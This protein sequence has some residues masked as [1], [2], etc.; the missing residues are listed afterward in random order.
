MMTLSTQSYAI[1][2]DGIAVPQ[3]G[4]I[5]MHFVGKFPRM[6]MMMQF[7]SL[8]QPEFIPLAVYFSF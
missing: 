7:R 1:A 5:N 4:M 3:I 2:V 6:G 8:K